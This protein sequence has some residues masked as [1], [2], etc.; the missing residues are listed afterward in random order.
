MLC[1]VMLC[2]VLFFFINIIIVLFL[3][4]MKIDLIIL[5]TLPHEGS[6]YRWST[7]ELQRL[8][9]LRNYENMFETGV[10]QANEC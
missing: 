3:Y 5:F 4:T 6:K 9:H 1:Y 8:E 7:D 2:F 10:V